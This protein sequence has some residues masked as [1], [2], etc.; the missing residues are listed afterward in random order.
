MDRFLR[1]ARIRRGGRAPNDALQQQQQQTPG[2]P[3][4]RAQISSPVYITRLKS[5]HVILFFFFFI[6]QC[7]PSAGGKRRQLC[8]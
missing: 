1:S 5:H 4:I 3:F 7:S 8:G 6:Q 2:G